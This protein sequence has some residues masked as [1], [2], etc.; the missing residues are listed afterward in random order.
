MPRV[1][2]EWSRDRREVLLFLAMS[3]LH[4]QCVFAIRRGGVPL[5]DADRRFFDRVLLR[6]SQVVSMC[7]VL[8]AG[9]RL[10]FEV[11]DIFR[12]HL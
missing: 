8:F 4:R 3:V 2:F 11:P 5:R 1:V 7:V 10:L 9:L 6:V 12:R